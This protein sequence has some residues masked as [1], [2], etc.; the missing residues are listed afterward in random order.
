MLFQPTNVF[1]SLSGGLGNGVIDAD[2]EL[3]VSWQVN[4]NTQLTAFQI[5]IYKNDTASTKVY[6]T[7]KLTE[8]CP[9]H[10][11][12]ST[13][14]IQFFSYTI[15][16]TALAL[17]GI[18]NG[19]EYK[20]VITQYS[21][22]T[23]V[24]QSAASAFKTR[25]TPTISLALFPTE[26][27]Y[28]KYTFT[29]EYPDDA[30]PLNWARW[31]IAEWSIG[32]DEP[33]N[34]IH[35]S[36]NIFSATDLQ[37]TYDGFLSGTRYAV[38][39]DVQTTYGIEVS[40]GW[41]E[42]K[43]VYD[44]AYYSGV[45]EAKKVCRSSGILVSWAG[46]VHIPGVPTSDASYSVQDGN[47]NLDSGS[48]SWD[49]VNNDDMSFAPNWSF[50]FRGKIKVTSSTKRKIE[51]KTDDGTYYV[52][53]SA[54]KSDGSGT[55]AV[56]VTENNITVS[57]P[58]GTVIHQLAITPKFIAIQ[59][60]YVSGG[61]FP[62]TDLYP[63][64]TLYPKAATYSE[65]TTFNSVDY[66]QSAIN[67]IKLSAPIIA[68]YIWVTQQSASQSLVREIFADE[69]FSPVYGEDKTLFAATFDND[70]S[71]GNVHGIKNAL[72]EAKIYR[73]KSGES[74]IEHLVDLPITTVYFA[75][76][77]V[78]SQSTYQYFLYPA[79]GDK[80]ELSPI[81][82]DA[83]TVCFWDWTLL[84]CELDESGHYRV[85]SEYLF[86][87]NLT[88]GTISNNNSPN[89]LT[90]FTQY[91]LVQLS[92]SNYK[93]GTL[94]SLIGV[95]DSSGEYSDTLTLRDA[96]YSLSTTQNTLFLKSRKGDVM[97]VAI[98]GAISMSTMDDTAAQAQTVSLSWTEI[99]SVDGLSILS[100]QEDSFFTQTVGSV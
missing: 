58:E 44:L 51:I 74:K 1:P 52:R 34:V 61:L 21:G 30:D 94:S 36:G 46:L 25:A 55:M 68:D 3:T 90:N 5:V 26:L 57:M 19:N 85:L 80:I 10:G 63:S 16:A 9:F 76:Y 60:Q 41:V 100:L 72:E 20:L 49:T 64:T 96:I 54:M 15:T 11:I 38:R 42:F 13:G 33:D 6:D 88:S 62:Q 82:S 87:K 35:D 8:G 45:L 29:A 48:I 73:M 28:S 86:G 7:G 12:S 18:T 69:S 77:S 99:G 91:P 71:A 89:T 2:T 93:S 50:F 84:E 53:T 75:D 83:V 81:V 43:S 47:L 17:A 56:H 39:C 98:S 24:V 14:E 79:S 22:S 4:G 59:A 95:I 97:H 40:T 66:T 23:S 65:E 32:S 31:R 27:P 78:A 37:C 67:E 70:L 92:N